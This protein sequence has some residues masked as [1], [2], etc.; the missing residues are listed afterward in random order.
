MSSDDIEK[1]RREL[2]KFLKPKEMA[3]VPEALL[4]YISDV[5]KERD[6]LRRKL[7]DTGDQ[8]RKYKWSYWN[9]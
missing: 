5:L 9:R 2:E 6:Q 3:G 7:G 1:V 8:L 4:R